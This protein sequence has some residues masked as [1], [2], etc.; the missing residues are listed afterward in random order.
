MLYLL[1][2][3]AD[4]SLWSSHDVAHG[5]FR[6]Y[7]LASF[8]ALWAPLPLRARLCS[9]YNTRLYPAVKAV[10]WLNQQLGRSSGENDTDLSI[11]PRPVN[12]WLEQ[13]LAGEAER[14]KA[15]VD[16]PNL[17]YARGVSLV[18]LLEKQG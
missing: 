15:G 7:T 13:I 16:Q 8:R 3:P 6:R 11:P 14:L 17:P 10:R 9:Y 2:V 5:H 18:A 4:P 12:R 1:T